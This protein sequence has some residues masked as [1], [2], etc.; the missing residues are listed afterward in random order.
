[1]LLTC[2]NSFTNPLQNRAL[3]SLGL[4]MAQEANPPNPFH[5]LQI[6][7]KS[8][9]KRSI[10][11]PRAPH[12]SGGPSARSFLNASNPSKILHKTMHSGASDASWLRMPIRQI[13]SRCFKSFTNPLQNGALWSIRRLMAQ[14]RPVGATDE[15]R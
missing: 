9:T 13:I 12:G 11:E 8:F 7:C 10:L 6:L 15:P 14:D 3:W 4:F 2:F 1:M 5:M